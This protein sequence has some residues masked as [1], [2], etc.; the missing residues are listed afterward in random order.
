M[1][2]MPQTASHTM[3]FY[4]HVL[5]HIYL[6]LMCGFILL[7]FHLILTTFIQVYSLYHQLVINQFIYSM[8]KSVLTIRH[9]YC[10]ANLIIYSISV[11]DKCKGFS[12]LLYSKFFKLLYECFIKHCYLISYLICLP[13]IKVTCDYM[14]LNSFISEIVSQYILNKE[15]ILLINRL[16]FSIYKLKY[17]FT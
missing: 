4:I 16:K 6:S 12:F 14:I 13:N 1:L 15:K 5:Q 3:K 11:G 10:L 7:F 9:F 2:P 8:P 17:I